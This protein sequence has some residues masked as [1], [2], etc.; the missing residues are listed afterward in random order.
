MDFDKGDLVS[1]IV[2]GRGTRM[3]NKLSASKAKVDSTAL[4]PVRGDVYPNG[5]VWILLLSLIA[6]IVYIMFMAGW[7]R[8]L[9]VT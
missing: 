3:I 6:F 8:F 7:S 4:L 1:P 5:Y 2:N 9:V